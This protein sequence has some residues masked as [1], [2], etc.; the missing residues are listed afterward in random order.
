MPRTKIF[1]PGEVNL[2]T[3]LRYFR[4][5]LALSQAEMAEKLGVSISLYTKLEIAA[6]TTNSRRID[7]FAAALHTTPEFLQYGTGTEYPAGDPANLPR[8]TDEMLTKILTLAADPEIQAASQK[9]SASTGRTPVQT[10]VMLI[11]A[12]VLGDN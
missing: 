10:M 5:K 8:L 3:Q 4:K 12:M 1:P 7:R 2:A 11:K 9:I 6:I